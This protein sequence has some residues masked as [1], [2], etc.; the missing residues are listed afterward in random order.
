M[1]VKVQAVVIGE[2]TK[3]W[4]EEAGHMICVTGD[5]HGEFERLGSKHFPGGP[6]DYLIIC[7][8]FGGVWTISIKSNTGR[9]GFPKS[10]LPRFS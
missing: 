10:R 6:G 5:T 7:G 9:N 1:N 4:R 8:D 3:V 2:H